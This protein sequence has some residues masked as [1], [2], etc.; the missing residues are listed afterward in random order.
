MDND[1]A[2]E[3]FLSDLL[4]QKQEERLRREER[5]RRTDE[6]LTQTRRVNLGFVLTTWRFALVT[7]TAF[8]AL[9]F[10]GMQYILQN[11]AFVL[12]LDVKE[13]V[14]V[15]ERFFGRNS[16][17]L[18]TVQVMTPTQAANMV[19]IVVMVVAG[20]SI[21]INLAL[22]ALQRRCRSLGNSEERELQVHGVFSEMRTRDGLIAF[23][24]WIARFGILIFGIVALWYLWFNR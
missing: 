1:K 18:N 10:A 5:Q 15:L 9:A 17:L 23:P 19:A 2:V 6:Q 20:I 7:R 11:L 22:A 24:F 12:K 16:A 8:F 21:A 3:K 14:A 13:L 4:E